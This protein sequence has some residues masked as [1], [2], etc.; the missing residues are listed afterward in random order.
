MS[1]IAGLGG[2]MLVRRVSRFTFILSDKLARR[3]CLCAGHRWP[4]AALAGGCRSR[5]S[6]SGPLKFAGTPHVI[7]TQKIITIARSGY[8]YN[9]YLYIVHAC[10]S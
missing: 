1:F 3:S 2:G 5:H 6:E 4:T 10:S 9:E 8:V 7:I